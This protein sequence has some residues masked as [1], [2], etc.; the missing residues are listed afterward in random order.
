[1]IIKK[2]TKRKSKYTPNNNAI[3]NEILHVGIRFGMICII[4]VVLCVVTY[5]NLPDIQEN[6]KYYRNNIINN[7]D[8]N[9]GIRLDTTKSPDN[10]GVMVRKNCTFKDGLCHP[11]NINPNFNHKM[12]HDHSDYN[13]WIQMN[14]NKN[15]FDTKKDYK[16]RMDVRDTFKYAWDSYDKHWYIIVFQYYNTYILYI[17]I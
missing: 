15:E 12:F 9:N 7:N 6:M 5:I 4:F 16:R 3:N 13:Y 2:Q 17:F 11:K 1:M 8:N 14:L 10:V